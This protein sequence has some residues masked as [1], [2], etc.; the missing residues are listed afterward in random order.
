MLQ[1]SFNV[2]MISFSAL[3]SSNPDAIALKAPLPEAFNPKP[4]NPKPSN[5]RITESCPRNA[6]LL[7]TL[8]MKTYLINAT[9]LVMSPRFR[10]QGLGFR[11]VLRARIAKFPE[12]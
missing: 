2:N 1:R 6:Y 11:H 9:G 8:M 12:A 10:V 7:L 3:L 4:R 5:A